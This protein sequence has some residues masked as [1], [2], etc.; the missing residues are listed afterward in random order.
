MKIPYPKH[1]RNI[2]IRIVHQDVEDG[3]L[4]SI[5]TVGEVSLSEKM[6]DY[7]VRLGYSNTH[8]MGIIVQLMTQTKV[9]VDFR[10][11]TERLELVELGDRI[12][13]SMAISMLEDF[14]SEKTAPEEAQQAA[15]LNKQTQKIVVQL[16]KFGKQDNK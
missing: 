7:L 5:R 13:S 15:S 9:R 4:S 10:N 6:S 16:P 12:T 14:I 1:P 8:I 11:Y 3:L 2:R